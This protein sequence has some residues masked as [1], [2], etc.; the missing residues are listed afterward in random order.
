MKLLP[1]GIQ[2]FSKIRQNDY[3]Y[4]DKTKHAYELAKQG[5]FYFL[6]RPRRFGK[7]LFLDTLHQLFAC[8]RELFSGLFIENKWD[9][10]NPYPLIRISF[11]GGVAADRADLGKI[12]G[13][14]MR[15]N[16]EDLAID[17]DREYSDRACFAELIRL[18][19]AK[20][21]Q[22]VVILIDE[23][24]K[25]I[26]DQ[27]EKPELAADIRE[28]LKDFYSVI[29]DSEQYIRLVFLTG[30]S[31]FSKVSL[32]SGLN[33]L[34]D[35]TLNSDFSTVCGYTHHDLET[36]FAE[37]LQGVDYEELRR[38][39]NGYQWL[40][41]PV[42]NP[43]DILLF[44]SNQ[45]M[46]R[47]YWFETGSPAFLIK[48]FRKHRYF[49]PELNGVIANDDLLPVTLLFQTGYLTIKHYEFQAGNL[50]FIL[51]T[52]NREVQMALNNQCFIGYTQILTQGPT[53]QR[54][55]L[56]L[57]ANGDVDGLHK[58]IQ[59]LF[60]AIPYRNFTAKDLPEYEG[61][62]ASVLYAFFASLGLEIIPE[63]ITN[64]GQVD[65]TIK[66]E[67]HVYIMEIKVI[68]SES[69]SGNPALDQ[70]LE[71]GYAEKY[72]GLPGYN[73]HQIGVVFSS[74]TRNI[75]VFTA[76]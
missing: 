71:R 70:L 60:A 22:Q 48:L 10:D 15:R 21:G 57:L 64:H 26:L 4:I 37:H 30:V 27:I 29:K 67:G 19:H 2:T 46:Y 72:Q 33:N 39:Y 51:D 35:I 24:D 66:A 34:Q 65:L 1:I 7:S 8:R 20:N 75:V 44:I 40:G 32:F 9:W 31:K 74:K 14:Q 6:S 23:Y 43:F 45:L 25:P 63:D 16:C 12:I 69:I 53:L 36:H 38:W 3:V 17:C 5:G 11:G 49:L 41:E 73:I 68:D 52:P 50:F 28:G 54:R 55:A 59:R 76:K 62:Y 61:Y 13:E 18:A 56:P 58:H 42:Y 47:S